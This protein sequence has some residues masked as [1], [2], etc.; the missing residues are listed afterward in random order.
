MTDELKKKARELAHRFCVLCPGVS[1]KNPKHQEEWH[2]IKCDRLTIAIEQAF[3]DC[4]EECAVVADEAKEKWGISAE[5]IAEAIR[6]K[7]EAK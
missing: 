5:E 2:D 4:I 7:G 6:R 1:P 3:Q